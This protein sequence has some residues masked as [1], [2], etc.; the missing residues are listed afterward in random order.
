MRKLTKITA[1]TKLVILLAALPASAWWPTIPEEQL[2]IR[3]DDYLYS[4]NDE[5]ATD[6]L[7]YDLYVV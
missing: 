5:R 6:R 7:R 2:I 3:E 1:V 4:G